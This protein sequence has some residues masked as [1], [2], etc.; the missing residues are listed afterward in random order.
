VA[1]LQKMRRLQGELL[2]AARHEVLAA[3]GEPGVDPEVVD[4]ILHQLDLRSYPGTE[5]PVR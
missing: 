2:S 3:R 5:P 4:R 1:R